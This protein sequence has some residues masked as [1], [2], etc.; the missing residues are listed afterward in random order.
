M[1]KHENNKNNIGIVGK[2][3]N[4][5]KMDLSLYKEDN[6]NKLE[7]FWNIISFSEWND[8]IEILKHNISD[9]RK[10]KFSFTIIIS[11]GLFRQRAENKNKPITSKFRR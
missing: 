6:K 10:E 8:I 4:L 1:E 9:Y 7:N 11:L 2:E 3:V 5:I